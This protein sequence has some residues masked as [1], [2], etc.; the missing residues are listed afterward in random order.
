MTTDNTYEAEDEDYVA[1]ILIIA[2][3][4]TASLIVA[5]VVMYMCAQSRQAASKVAMDAAR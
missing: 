3:G 1:L 2:G 5:A 4:V